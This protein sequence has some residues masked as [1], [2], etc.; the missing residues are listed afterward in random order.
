M[1]WAIL[2]LTM[3]F[4]P[5]DF[6]LPAADLLR[7][8]DLIE[9]G[10][11][12]AWASRNAEINEEL[13]DIMVDVVIIFS[14]LP[15]LLHS[16]DVI[17][18]WNASFEKL[19]ELVRGLRLVMDSGDVAP[20]QKFEGRPGRFYL[21]IEAEYFVTFFFHE[22]YDVLTAAD[23]LGVLQTES[24]WADPT[25]DL[26]ALYNFV[27][28][29]KSATKQVRKRS[30]TSQPVFRLEAP[31]MA[32]DDVVQDIQRWLD[33]LVLVGC[34]LDASSANL[35][36]IARTI[37]SAEDTSIYRFLQSFRKREFA[38][39]YAPVQ[40]RANGK[41]MVRV[42]TKYYF[43][44][45]ANPRIFNAPTYETIVKDIMRDPDCDCD[46]E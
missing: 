44:Y 32:R 18:K 15:L 17:D 34:T 7:S 19:F 27:R 38:K 23:N 30:S 12:D 37:D 2:G 14:K 43:E 9:G 36:A 39:L 29:S 13:Q 35:M 4:S 25:D 21:P 10:R 45:A 3:S 46:L 16:E 28:E 6:R 8:L 11:N 1:C 40:N 26:L 42:L 20:Q 31:I 5:D 24:A 22:F 41:I 33:E